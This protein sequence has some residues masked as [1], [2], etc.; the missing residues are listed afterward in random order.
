MFTIIYL[1]SFC[2]AVAATG[3]VALDLR[4]ERFLIPAVRSLLTIAL[5]W[6][7]GFLSV[8]LLARAGISVPSPFALLVAAPLVVCALRSHW[9]ARWTTTS[10]VLGSMLLGPLSLHALTL[11]LDVSCRDLTS[12]AARRLLILLALLPL[13]YIAHRFYARTTDRMLLDE[14]SAEQPD[15]F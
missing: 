15:A 7:A 11:V 5:P 10:V 4:D 12:G 3:V 6:L 13:G 14:Q 9:R 8:S 2:L 1:I